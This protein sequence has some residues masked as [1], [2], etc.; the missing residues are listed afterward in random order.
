MK[1]QLL[2]L[3]LPLWA[4]CGQQAQVGSGASNA[5]A[6]AVAPAA[7]I[8]PEV[9]PRTATPLTNLSNQGV[10]GSGRYTVFTSSNASLVSGD[11]NGLADVF[12]YDRYLR[13]HTRINL[14]SGGQQANGDSRR[15]CISYDGR[16]IAFDS[17]ASNLVAGD[18]NNRR[19][20]FV[21]DR[22]S[23]SLT[24]LTSGNGDSDQPSVESN[25]D[26]GISLRVA[27]RTAATDLVTPD[28]NGAKTDVLCWSAGNLYRVNQG[29]S[30]Q[31]NGD[32]ANPY[33]QLNIVAFDSNATNLGPTSGR[34][35][36]YT[37]LFDGS[38]NAIWRS[39]RSSGG[40]GNGASYAPVL[41]W[42]S[43]GQGHRIAFA[44]SSNNL[45]AGDT[46]GQ[47]DLFWI[48]EFGALNSLARI[49]GP[50][51]GKADAPAI[52]WNGARLGYTF[53]TKVGGVRSDIYVHDLN[54]GTAKRVS[55]SSSG[56]PA[57][58]VSQ[59]CSLDGKGEIVAFRSYGS[60]LDSSDN[61]GTDDDIFIRDGE[62]YSATFPLTQVISQA[63]VARENPERV[64]VGPNGPG[65]G[66]VLGFPGQF[67]GNGRFVVF[68]SDAT[69]LV[70]GAS[71]LQVY[72]R[73]M[74]TGN[75]EL[76]SDGGQGPAN[77]HAASPAISADGRFVVFSSS[78]TNLV[79]GKTNGL[80][81]VY[82]RDRVQGTL[83]VISRTES[84]GYA[85]SGQ[86]PR[87]VVS[88]D[89]RYVCWETDR[90]LSSA[91]P[92]TLWDIY[93]RDRQ[94]DSL[95]LLS[96]P[97]AGGLKN[98]S[99]RDPSISGDGR[100][101]AFHT[102]SGLVASD[103]GAFDVYRRDRSNGTLL[104]CSQNQGIKGNS[105]SYTASLSG[106][107]RHVAFTSLASNLVGGLDDPVVF[108][109][110]LF[111]ANDLSCD[112]LSRNVPLGTVGNSFS[113]RL[114]TDDQREFFAF[115]SFANN[116]VSG[117]TNGIVDIFIARGLDGDV[118]R[119]SL[120]PN[121]GQIAFHSDVPKLSR[122]GRWVTY[123]SNS[124]VSYRAL[125]PW[126]P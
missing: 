111:D 120:E 23:S 96:L 112:L 10:D 42:P 43:N 81:D 15:A 50:V 87:S 62:G 86:S 26:A 92:D 7:Q 79:A 82:L 126:L 41:G 73:D 56:T 11:T 40:E 9:R 118:R 68:G 59:S 97:A 66:V 105:S 47:D 103:A 2:L 27:F 67:S 124:S 22:Q 88:D 17:A 54:A 45:V 32:S 60:N 91:D 30:G 102:D 100:Y 38:A 31:S 71:G 34:R 20:V 39:Q 116:L 61:N 74:E 63:T 55:L 93:L 85:T 14:D 53:Q 80:E 1:R 37:N 64:D 19:D 35:H 122:N 28:A 49:A 117:D 4:G 18:S 125:N 57:N 106:N 3:S 114:S 70:A 121:G 84:G 89:G 77:A 113:D 119:V 78:A 104:L 58:E 13:K 48:Q 12:L 72:L 36:V 107:G 95:E 46:N 8:P 115:L 123:L 5:V 33:V 109:V 52:S 94:T 83:E 101:V 69:N 21:Y 65:N 6:E 98:G 29:A 24:R 76:I 90:Q 108:D 25:P 99:S 16:Y 75:I 51:S 44:S 110:F